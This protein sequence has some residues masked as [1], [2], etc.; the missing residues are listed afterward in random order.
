MNQSFAHPLR[1]TLLTGLAAI[2]SIIGP[3][4]ARALDVIS[5]NGTLYTA[6]SDNSHFNDSYTSANLFDFDMTGI[7]VGTFISSDATEY[8][9]VGDGT[10][11]VAFQLDQVYTNIESIFYANRFNTADFVGEISIWTSDTTAFTAADPGTSPVSAVA[12]TNDVSFG[13]VWNE[14]A[15]T[16]ALHGQYFLLRLDE[17]TPGGGGNPGGREFRLG[18]FNARPPSITAQSLGK[19]VYATENI[20]L[21]VQATGPVPLTYQWFKG[22]AMLSDGGRISGS[23]NS[24]LTISN[25][26]TADTAGYTCVV[27][28]NYGAVTSAVMNVMVDSLPTEPVALA[29]LSNSPAA[30]WQLDESSGATVA[31]EKVAGLNG[32]YG[33]SAGVGV[34][35]PQPPDF[36]GF[37][38]TNMAVQTAA[39]VTSSI[40]SLPPV[41]L[42]G[43][44]GG[45]TITA[46]IYNDVSGGSQNPYT[47]IVFCRG[48]STVAGLICSGDGTQLDY[49]WGANGYDFN[50]GLVLPPNQWS[51]VAIVY[52]ANK[53]SLYCSSNGIVSQAV[54]N[55]SWQVQQFDGTTC[56]GLDPD[57][58]ESARTF[59]G[60]IDEV[61][62]YDHA[63]NASQINALFAAGKGSLTIVPLAITTQPVAPAPVY[64]TDAFG[65]SATVTGT[66]PIY[67]WYKNSVAISGATNNVYNVSS[68]K[69]S[70][71]G[72][73]YLVAANQANSVTSSVVAVTVS[74]L[75][76][77]AIDPD[78]TLYTGI[79]D[80]NH[81]NDSYTAAN[82]FDY[83]MTG[84]AA[85][86]FI[87][88]DATEYA[89]SGDG[90]CFVAFQLDHV[91]TN[92]AS[93]FYASRYNTPD[94]VS[95]IDIWVS[96]TSAFTAVDPGTNPNMMVPITKDITTGAVYNEYYLTSS[97]HGRYF[98]LRLDQANPGTG[99]NP[100]GREFR[101]GH[102][103]APGL[104]NFTKNAS[105]L[106]FTWTDGVLQQAPAVTGPWTTA[107]GVTS[108]VPVPT[109]S[110]N[111]FFRISY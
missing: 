10:C 3:T 17:K 28:N 47:G 15:L 43:A 55:R 86:T 94:L 22:T 105:G 78:G 104:L 99:G 89:R 63:L 1:V 107:T 52:Q 46:W 8:A 79:S 103:F 21:S 92:I 83:N 39:F 34:A 74:N 70:D 108:G 110:T 97:L 37:S 61:A 100:G 13:A 53:V 85:G 101:L 6:I 62:L 88:F 59:N 42:T 67:Q 49:Q 12:I 32:L 26:S 7:A 23:T 90:V 16:G 33:S 109:T 72:N 14:Y 36:P 106:T 81:F 77:R 60:S 71:S 75:L 9:R 73:Y 65:L 2:T 66:A 44:N 41:F 95:N 98:L 24:L 30:Y 35:G 91:Y 102:S 40:V 84:I 51:F 31:V 58:G 20:R 45:E 18:Q 54:D 111:T 68:A 76:S 5:P 38:T 57:L 27:A 48:G 25:L 29:V 87:P 4:P 64:L 11:F 82:L 80:N 93:I 56:I 69:V 96:D 50:S 19:E